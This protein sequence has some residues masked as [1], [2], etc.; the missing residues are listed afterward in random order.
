MQIF[1]ILAL[2][3]AILAVIFAI[4][5]TAMVTI[6]FFAWTI[7]TPLAVALLIAL[8]AGVLITILLSVPGR[9]KGSWHSVSQ[10]KKYSALEGERN[11][12]QAKVEE[13][14]ADRDKYLKNW[15]DAELEISNLEQQTANLSGA[16]EGM[17][18]N[19]GVQPESTQP[20]PKVS[21]EPETSPTDSEFP[22]NPPES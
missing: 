18:T 17:E 19:T 22:S 9:I 3:I 15:E 10:R 20:M 5:N 11:Q 21:A 4:Q 12:L 7:H 13:M 14:T 16:L 6:S 2:L 8:G 1:L